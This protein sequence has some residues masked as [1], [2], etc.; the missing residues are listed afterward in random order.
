[1][2][3]AL[4]LTVLALVASPW[5]RTAAEAAPAPA[6]EPAAPARTRKIDVSEYRVEGAE[7]L[8]TAELEAVLAPF[9]GPGRELEDVEKARAA[10]EKAYSDK[11]FQS[12]TVAI[13]PQTVRDGI[14]ALQVTESKVGRLRVRGARWFSPL[15]V[16]H[17]AASVAEGRVPNFNA[18]VGDIVALNQLP[19]RRVTPALKPGVIPGTIDVDLNVEDRLPLHGSLDLDN[20][21]SA[22]TTN[23]RLNG[24]L[25]Y[26]NLL[27]RGHSLTFAF[28]TAPRRFK[29]AEVFSLAYLARVPGASWLTLNLNGVIQDSDVS[30]LGSMAVRGKGQIF[31]GRAVFTLPGTA[32]FFHTVS[33]GLDYKRFEEGLTL[34]TDTLQTPVTYW[35]VTTQYVATWL[36]EPSQTQLTT[37]VVFNVRGL[38]SPPSQFDAKRYAASGNFMYYRAEVSRTQNLRHGVQLLGRLQGQYASDPLVASEQMTAGGAESVRGYLEAEGAGDNGAVGSLEVRTPSFSRWLGASH[39]NEWR[40][41][42]FFEGGKLWV[43]QALPEQRS[44][45]LLWG[46]GAGTRLRLLDHLY[47]SADV[48]VPLTMAGATQRYHPKFHLRVAGEF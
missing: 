1:M 34:S 26:D 48:G 41:L 5:G 47:A 4:V 39:V 40:L 45:F 33:W 30:T 42:A 21:Q 35:P 25:H 23:L 19:D 11:G 16:K 7:Q 27:Q 31:G 20:R 2:R 44:F 13:P 3:T 29:D 32:E 14:V 46:T 18:I 10:L 28:Q 43:R 12:V 22:N 8:T 6:G 37:S 17:Q 36:D 15:D 24:L 38:G 9:L